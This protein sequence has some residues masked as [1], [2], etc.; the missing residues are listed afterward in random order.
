MKRGKV[1]WRIPR[2]LALIFAGG[3][4]GRLFPLTIAQCDHSSRH[5][6]E[7]QTKP[8]TFLVARNSSFVNAIRGPL[9]DESFFI[10]N[11]MSVMLKCY[12]AKAN[13]HKYQFSRWYFEQEIVTAL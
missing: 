3:K 6:R 2:V 8:T 13:E 4:A 1:E 12:F 10:E 5:Y 7:A 11:Y 9:S